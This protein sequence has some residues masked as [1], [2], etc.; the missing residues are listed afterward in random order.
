MRSTYCT[1]AVFSLLFFVAA[2]SPAQGAFLNGN[3]VRVDYLFPTVADSIGDP[4]LNRIAV[5]GSGVEF[6]DFLNLDF[7]DVD[8]TDT[9]L[10]L[11][12]SKTAA[13]GSP[14][15]SGIRLSD[16]N[17]TIAAFT[18]VTVKPT[19]TLSGFGTSNVTFDSDNVF[20]NLSG[21]NPIQGNLIDININA[22]SI[23]PTA[24]D[25]PEPASV[26]T[27]L[28]ALGVVLLARRRR[29]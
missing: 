9:G 3:T 8:I 20:V 28:S 22:S 1:Q 6:I 5:V 7:L 26:F 14:A 24:I 21:L 29:S 12:F 13:G 25:V 16:I 15:F 27:A 17:S 18:S 2:L 23:D 11:S 19:T 10:R 4:A